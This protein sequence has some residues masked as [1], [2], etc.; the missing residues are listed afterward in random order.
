[1]RKAIF[2][3]MVLAAFSAGAWAGDWP[4]W[5][6]PFQNGSTDQKNLPGSWSKTE[7]IRW[8]TP[9]PGPGAATPIIWGDYVF[10]SS[11]DSNSKDLYALCLDGL[12]GKIV[13]QSKAGRASESVRRSNM[14]SPSPVT[15]G[16]R[17]Y[18][19]YGTS[20]LAAF[21]F[22]GNK[23]WSRRL[24][25]DYGVFNIK[26]GYSSSP[27][28]YQD[29]LY[30]I[31]LRRDKPYSNFPADKS[32]FD[33]F[34][35]ALDSRT[36]EVIWK[37]PRR[38]GAKKE[39]L[40]AYTT[41]VLYEGKKRKEIVVA[42]ADYVTGHDPAT[43]AE[44]W[45]LLYNPKHKDLQRLVPSAV[46]GDGLIYAV[47]PRG[48]KELFAIR[49]GGS[50]EIPWSD[51]AWVFEK[52][53]PDVCTP[54]YY[55]GRLYVLDGNKKV[56]SCLHAETGRQIWQGKLGGRSVFRASPT[57]ADGKIYCVSQAGQ[58]VVLGAGDEFKVIS[59]I[60]MGEKPVR[61]SIA[62]AGGRLFIRTAKN[63]YCVGL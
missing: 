16:K 52:F 53:T 54:L 15:D 32:P 24:A 1:M 51:L 46:A 38:S 33:S 4:Q 41:P 34:L 37:H 14:A 44:F 26:F 29:K 40:D 21:D 57:G 5:R 42:G 50:G 6:G 2:S 58:V 59:R 39:S 43:G 22:K 35:L 28:L 23:T 56:M 18:F 62:A 45:H 7:N 60:S 47:V 27:L 9:L 11:I 61:A 20:D 55:N 19:L 12:S 10:I 48:G 30:V 3:M 31:L 17:V 49:E 25:K 63:L 13:W 36:G 8:V